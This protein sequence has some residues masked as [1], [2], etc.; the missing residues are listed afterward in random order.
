M[1]ALDSQGIIAGQSPTNY[2]SSMVFNVG[3]DAANA[4]AEQTA[5]GLVLQQ[6]SDQRSAISGVNLDEEA[7]NMVQFQDAYAASA[8]VVTTI[9]DMMYSVIQMSTLT[10]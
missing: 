7:A 1:Y 6:L 10:G 8:Q 9:N 5:S 2:Y 3:T 4:S